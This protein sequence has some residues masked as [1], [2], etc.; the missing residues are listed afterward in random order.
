MQ[1]S[2]CRALI[3]ALPITDTSYS[4]TGRRGADAHGACR[5][6][7]PSHAEGDLEAGSQGQC[8]SCRCKRIAI[9]RLITAN[10][11]AVDR[12]N[13][14]RPLMASRGPAPHRPADRPDPADLHRPGPQR[15]RRYHLQQGRLQ[16]DADP[17]QRPGRRHPGRH[18]FF[19][20]KGLHPKAQ[21]R[22]AHP[23]FA[24]HSPIR[25]PKAFHQGHARPLMQPLWGR[26]RSRKPSPQGTLADSRPRA[27]GCNPF[28]A[29]SG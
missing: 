8:T 28:R 9:R 12:P 3:R 14:N 16:H 5:R 20:P 24:E 13:S 19:T 22:T 26:K 1:I 23:G 25:T 15:A 6:G 27:L 4:R 17:P 21:G 11:T 18:Q 2:L 7:G 10:I 29:L